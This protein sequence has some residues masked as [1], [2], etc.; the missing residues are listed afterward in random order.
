M[1]PGSIEQKFYQSMGKTQRKL[2]DM[3][4]SAKDDLA[5]HRDW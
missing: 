2:A 5:D 1:P 3:W 4:G